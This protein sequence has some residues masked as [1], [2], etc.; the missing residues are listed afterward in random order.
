MPRTSLETRRRILELCKTY[1]VAQIQKRLEEEKICVS[2][3]TIYAIIKKYRVHHTYA[4]LPKPHRKTILNKDQVRFIDKAMENNDELTGR[5]LHE[6]LL[7]IWPDLQISITTIKKVRRML[8]WVCSRPKYC[9]LVREL[10]KQKRV[11]WCT[12]RIATQENFD[13]V[14]FTDECSIQLDNHGRLCFRKRGS[15]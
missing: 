1:P 4:D 6:L 8:G 13:D 10:N 2:K 9:Q 14:I 3:V 7:E 12:E 15:V 11:E 5:Q